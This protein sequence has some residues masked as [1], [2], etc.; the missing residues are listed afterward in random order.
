MLEISIETLDPLTLVQLAG[1]TLIAAVVQ[2]AVGFGFSLLAVS[3]FLLIIQSGDAV[4]LLIIINFTISLALIAK[5]RR[6]VN[7]ALWTRLVAGALLGLPL[8][9]I[10]FNNADVDQLRILA[11]VAILTFVVITVFR[12]SDES[13][14]T[15]PTEGFRNTSALGVGAIAGIDCSAS[16][17]G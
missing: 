5:V 7:W 11:G 10:A 6:D 14:R 12:R 4:H 17:P 3:F 15:G 2:G 8:G 16:R 1:V 9:L 13:G